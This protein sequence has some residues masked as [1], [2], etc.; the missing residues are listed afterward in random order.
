[1]AGLKDAERLIQQ[2]PD[3]SDS[4]AEEVAQAV[5]LLQLNAEA[6][7]DLRRELAAATAKLGLLQDAHG[8]LA[9]AALCQGT[10]ATATAA[11]AAAAGRA[12]GQQPGS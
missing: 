2:L 11:A 7:Q 6:S 5:S 3:T 10:A 4:E 12:A 1:M 8:V 9:E